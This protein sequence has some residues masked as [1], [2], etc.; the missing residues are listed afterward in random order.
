ME[1][2]GGLD[3]GGTGEP[4]LNPNVFNKIEPEIVVFLGFPAASRIKNVFDDSLWN[5]DY[6]FVESFA[7]TAEATRQVQSSFPS[8]T[9][10]ALDIKFTPT[11]ELGTDSGM[12]NPGES[13][14]V[15]VLF[16]VVVV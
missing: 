1:H 3:R 2:V 5:Q 12:G 16:L 14:K 8:R 6:L 9:T 7:G 4:N 11:M 10:V 13:S 15:F